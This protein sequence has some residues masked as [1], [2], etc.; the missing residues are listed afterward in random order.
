M[1]KDQLLKMLARACK[2]SG[3]QAN[4]AKAHGVSAAYVSDV[5]AG[6]RE[7]GD[8]VLAALGVERVMVYRKVQ[9]HG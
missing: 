4:W 7:S 2:R 6:R 5:L 8:K 1:D 3:S 9:T